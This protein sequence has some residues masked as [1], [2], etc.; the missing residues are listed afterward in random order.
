[1]EVRDDPEGVLHQACT[2]MSKHAINSSNLAALAILVS[3]MLQDLKPDGGKSSSSSQPDQVAAFSQRISI[4]SKARAA[5]GTLQLLRIFVHRVLVDHGTDTSVLND[6]FTY[7]NRDSTERDRDTDTELLNTLLVFLTANGLTASI[8]ETPEMYD[9]AML[10]LQLLIVMLSTQLYQPMLSSFQQQAQQGTTIQTNYFLDRIMEHARH[11]QAKERQQEKKEKTLS[12]S[13]S[14]LEKGGTSHYH[15][16]RQSTTSWTAKSVL[17][18]CLTWQIQRPK[19]PERSIAFYH[20]ELARSVV[21]AKGE[22]VGPDGMYENNLVVSAAAEKATRSNDSNIGDSSSSFRTSIT[23]SRA[24]HQP[25]FLLDTTKGV[26]VKASSIILLPFRLMSLAWGLWGHK[27]KGY[28]KTRRNH[29]NSHFRSSRTKDVI[30]ISESPVT[31]LASCLFLILTN[32]CRAV[33]DAAKTKEPVEGNPFRMDLS[34]LS[35]NRWEQGHD[36]SALPDL[37][38]PLAHP[39]QLNES[40]SLLDAFDKDQNEVALSGSMVMASSTHALTMNFETLFSSFGLILHTEVGALLLYTLLQSSTTFSETIAVR[41][42]LDTLVLPLL[43][44]LYFSS[45]TRHVAA[46]DFHSKSADTPKPV[47]QGSERSLAT[48]TT[49]AAL[50]I[51][52]CPFR[53]QSQLYVIVILLLLFSQDSSFGSDAFR[54]TNVETVPWYKERYL[55][56]IS[57]GSVMMLTLL[58]ALT[59]NLNRLHDMFLLSNCCAVLMNLSHSVVDLH[60]YAAMRLASVTVSCIKKYT[61]M[62][63]DESKKKSNGGGAEDDEESLLFDMYGE[64]SHTLLR[65]IKHTL[66]QKN[67]DRNLHLVYA[68]VYHQADFKK[69]FSMKHSPFKKSE[70]SRIHTVIKT[71]AKIIESKFNAR[72]ATKALQVLTESID[73]VREV[74]VEKKRKTSEKEDFTFTYEE[75]ADPE[76]FFV[77]YVWETVVCAVTA[78]S[79]EWDKNKILV[80]PLLEADEP[81]PADLPMDVDD[82]TSMQGPPAASVFAQDVMDVV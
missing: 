27:Q 44:T 51:R 57:L 55:K 59:F 58:R 11:T 35:D 32:N 72:T 5:A 22:K 33:K 26:L 40:M 78:S 12:N 41:S 61:S 76:I 47:R 43:R 1:M 28:D 16:K 3:E 65:L 30:W 67:I 46:Q 52:Q 56:D 34:A 63:I 14:N 54:R 29:L 82:S 73:E 71:A 4:V 62:A 23:G 24:A 80:F 13:N 19:S 31:D 37:P 8:R 79:V 18:T 39:A 66:T 74:L 20:A 77:P 64:V 60:E 25:S 42:D 2:S 49:G 6:I 38:D 68:L 10:A 81:P 7:R 45:Q 50:S 36:G 69:I 48:K 70:M 9:T 53:S 21:A 17:E 15:P 75:E